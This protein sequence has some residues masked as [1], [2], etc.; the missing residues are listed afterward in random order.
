MPMRRCVWASAGQA[1]SQRASGKTIERNGVCMD[2]SR[3]HPMP[4]SRCRGVDPIEIAVV[5]DVFGGAELALHG[6]FTA[7]I[8]QVVELLALDRAKHAVDALAAAAAA[9]DERSACELARLLLVEE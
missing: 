8:A 4:Q 9:R 2:P 6:D 7:G 1:S 3:A 5:V